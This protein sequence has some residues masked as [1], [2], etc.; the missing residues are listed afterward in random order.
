MRQCGIDANVLNRMIENNPVVQQARQMTARMQQEEGQRAM[1][2]QIDEISKI[3]PS[4]TDFNSLVSHPNFQQFNARV[5]QG[6][7]MVDAFKLAN[8]DQ[9][10]AKKAAAA[11]QAALNSVNGKNHLNP[12]KGAG[13]GEDIVVPEETMAMYRMAFKGWTN[14]QIIDDYKKRMNQ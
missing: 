8:Y 5:M 2:Q 11:K 7:S 3:D 1:Q 12:T 10:T 13:S 6:Y 4:V 14:Q 9:I